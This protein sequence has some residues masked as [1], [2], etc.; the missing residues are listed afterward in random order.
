M[1]KTKLNSE[2]KAI[3]RK[4]FGWNVKSIV[5][6]QTID[7]VG[8]TVFAKANNTSNILSFVHTFEVADSVE[9]SIS[10]SGDIEVEMGIKGKKVT[11][12]VDQKI[13]AEI[14]KKTKKSTVETTKTTIVIS[15]Y[16][17]L[18]VKIK[19]QARL[20]NGVARYY[21]LGIGFKKGTWEYIDV[22][23]EYYDYYEEKI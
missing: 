2:Y 10:V 23:N 16:T 5:K 7:Y 4:A 14:G 9:T 12:A 18:T 6:D 20:N 22:I 21:F 1:S 13:R 8:D 17:K 11:T 15:P 3:K 19:G